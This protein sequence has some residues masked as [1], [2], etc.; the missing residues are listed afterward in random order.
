MT[1]RRNKR[2]ASEGKPGTMDEGIRGKKNK[3]EEKKNDEEK[4]KLRLTHTTVVS[5]L[6]NVR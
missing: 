2:R 4:M 5:V 1:I 3:K 6:Y